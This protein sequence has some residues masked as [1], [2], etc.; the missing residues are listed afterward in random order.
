MTDFTQYLTKARERIVFTPEEMAD[1][2]GLLMQ[3]GASEDEAAEFLT[4]LSARGE[5]AGE[6]AGAARALRLRAA[7][8]DAPKGAIDCCGTGGDGLST[9]NI[10]TAVALVAA[11]CGAP[12]AKHGNRSASSKSGAADVL[13]KLGVNLMLSRDTQEQA[14]KELNFC[15]LMAPN[16][17]AAMKNVA[18]IR[19][20]L[21]T[22]TIFN[23]LGPLANPAGTKKQLVGV[24]A[25]RW[26]VPMAQALQSLG[27]EKALVVHG[28][29]GLDEITLTGRTRIAIL[30]NDIV[31]EATL[32]PRDF[33]LPVIT[34]EKIKGGDSTQNAAALLNILN[35]AHNDYRLIVLA[36]AAAVLT[37]HDDRPL[38]EGVQAAAEALDTGK[39]LNVLNA[40]R[41]LRA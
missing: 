39:A 41:E 6:I 32:L 29:D 5:T 20:K 22:R 19:K 4:V 14:L 30:K 15:F 7:T 21:G 28:E 27:C 37:L 40:Y 36:N 16:H 18:G 17:H 13:E 2:I 12:V 23:L 24:F 31:T 35:G 26:I 25:E 9:L 11:A 1:C 3:G 38:R 10:S 8:I 33:G 34:L